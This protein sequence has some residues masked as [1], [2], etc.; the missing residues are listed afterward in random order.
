[1]LEELKIARREADVVVLGACINAC[2]KR[3]SWSW[4]L[5]SWIVLDSLGARIRHFCACLFVED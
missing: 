5:E 3:S 4:A 1:M 2:K